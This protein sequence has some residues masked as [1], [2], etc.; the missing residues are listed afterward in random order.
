MFNYV[1]IMITMM[2]TMAMM[3]WI[4]NLVPFQGVLHAAARLAMDLRHVIYQLL[5]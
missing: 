3:K 2:T 1:L 5:S 4:I